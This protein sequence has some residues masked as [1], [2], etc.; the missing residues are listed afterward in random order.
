[1]TLEPYGCLLTMRSDATPGVAGA[2]LFVRPENLAALRVAL[3]REAVL[4]VR[5]IDEVVVLGSAPVARKAL[6]IASMGVDVVEVH[7]GSARALAVFA[8]AAER[9]MSRPP[10]P[11]NRLVVPVQRRL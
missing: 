5:E 9:A 8:Q 2:V 6:H 10:L 7:E 4:G 11:T 1:M 3:V